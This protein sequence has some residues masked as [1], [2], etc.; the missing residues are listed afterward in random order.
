MIPSL[1]NPKT[2]PTPPGLFTIAS[3]GGWPTVTKTFFATPNGI[4]TKIEAG[5]GV[6]TALASGIVAGAPRAGGRPARRRPRRPAR[7]P[8]SSGAGRSPST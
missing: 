5:M 1:V 6:S 2:F 7:S 8:A 4:V 3:L